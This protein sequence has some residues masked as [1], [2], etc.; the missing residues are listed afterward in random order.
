MKKFLIVTIASFLSGVFLSS[1]MISELD[2]DPAGTLP[3]ITTEDPASSES[4]DPIESTVEDPAESET[5]ETTMSLREEELEKAMLS[6][7]YT[8]KSFSL[9]DRFL[10]KRLSEGL[11]YANK[12]TADD[13]ES[14]VV[15]ITLPRVY[16][17]GEILS[18]IES[19]ALPDKPYYGGEAVT[20]EKKQ[21][22]LSNRGLQVFSSLDDDALHVTGYGLLTKNADLRSFPTS[23][24]AGDSA[25]DTLKD[26]F[27]ETKLNLGE[28]V[29]IL[30]HSTDR[31]WTFVQACNYAGWI[32]SDAVLEVSYQEFL[33]YL[34]AD[35]F[36]VSFGNDLSHAE[37]R[38]G[39]ILPVSV[40][41]DQ[42]AVV[43]IP[44]RDGISEIRIDSYTGSYSKG[45]ELFSSNAVIRHARALIGLPYGWGDAGTGTHDCSSFIMGLYRIFG[46]FL[47]RN[48]VSFPHAGITVVPLDTMSASEKAALIKEHPGAVI[49]AP[50]H[51]MLYAGEKNGEAVVIHESTGYTAKSGIYV[52]AMAV[53]ENKLS[54]MMQSGIP[55]IESFEYLIFVE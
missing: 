53:I 28:G 5:E 24:V 51:A 8:A 26:Y 9:K 47:P 38:L 52:D 13:P 54:D 15:D 43:L 20:E 27:Q 42:S 33:S 45:F 4:E 55:Y 37:I 30:N 7:E 22:L 6:L 19:Y 48:T 41:R 29:L 39:T 21:R 11:L 18:L 10:G 34:C 2:T 1:C 14:F 49:K 12:R 25:T 46:I 40:I 50:Q 36:L 3:L 44:T 16:T 35:S 17:N 23:E 31:L 32:L